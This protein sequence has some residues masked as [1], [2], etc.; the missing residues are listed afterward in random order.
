MLL[1]RRRPIPRLKPL[2]DTTLDD[3]EKQPRPRPLSLPNAARDPRRPFER[4]ARMARPVSFVGCGYSEA[5]I[6]LHLDVRTEQRLN[7]HG[8]LRCQLVAGAI[9]V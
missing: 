1:E 8:A 2:L 6:E 7:F 3:A 5:L 9:E 4:K